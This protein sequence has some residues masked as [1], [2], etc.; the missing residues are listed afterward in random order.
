MFASVQGEGLRQGKPTIFIRLTGCNLKCTFCDTRAAW[1]KG[2]DMSISRIIKGVEMLKQEFPSEWVCLTGGE[3]LLQDLHPLTSQLKER[4]FKIQIET[5]A[6]EFQA[7]PVD[8]YS[9]SPK[10]EEYFFRTEYL[11]A[12]REIKLVVDKDLE[13]AVI[14]QIKDQFPENTPLL[15]QPQSQK[16][17]SKR[18]AMF[19][20]REALQAGIRNI[21]LAVQLHKIYKIP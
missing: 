12:A 21:R 13:L 15:L 14:Q 9:I 17:W 1:Q 3:P 7:L 2:E 20:L 16:N 6:T 4:G 18:K 8:W 19:L 11:S 10:P 5:N